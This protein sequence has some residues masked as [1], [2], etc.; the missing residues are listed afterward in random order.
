MRFCLL[1]HSLHDPSHHT[2]LAS[3]SL[4]MV[5]L[6]VENAAMGETP[7]TSHPHTPRPASEA[8]VHGLASGLI[9]GPADEK[10]RRGRE[11]RARGC[12]CEGNNQHTDPCE[13]MCRGEGEGAPP[14]GFVPLRDSGPCERTRRALV[15]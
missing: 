10:P 15:G 5:K 2:I 11:T 4:N 12:G 1:A 13:W 8:P 7:H 14:S 6:T 9:Q 3:T